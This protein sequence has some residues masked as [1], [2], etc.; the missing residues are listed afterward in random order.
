[1]K[2]VIHVSV[3]KKYYGYTLS[4]SDQVTGTYFAIVVLDV[5]P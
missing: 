1:M 5:E 3:N 2:H 4:F